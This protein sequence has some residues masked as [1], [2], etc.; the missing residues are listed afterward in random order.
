MRDGNKHTGTVLLKLKE[1]FLHISD[2]EL[3]CLKDESSPEW[4]NQCLYSGGL[5]GQTAML[6]K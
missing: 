1:Q 5:D 3:H 6:N 4:M 2:K